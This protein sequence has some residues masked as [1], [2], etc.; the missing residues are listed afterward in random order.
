MTSDD[1]VGTYVNETDRLC[2]TSV[3]ERG[4]RVSYGRDHRPSSGQSDTVKKSF[5]TN[6]RRRSTISGSNS[7]TVPDFMPLDGVSGGVGDLRDAHKRTGMGSVLA[8]SLLSE[9]G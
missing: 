8:L 1:A 2:P 9:S 5:S 3:S 7:P 6:L 4:R